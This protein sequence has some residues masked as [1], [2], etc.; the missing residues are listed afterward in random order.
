M[1]VDLASVTNS[2]G[3][4]PAGTFTGLRA[5]VGGVIGASRWSTPPS[6]TQPT[7]VAHD[8]SRVFAF[9][10][11]PWRARCATSLARSRSPE[12]HAGAAR[13]V[14]ARGRATRD[15]RGRLVVGAASTDG[16][17]LASVTNSVGAGPAGT[18]TG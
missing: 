5:G 10:R 8:T 17:D 15:G 9:S 2:V 16:V 13:A 7:T 3:A 4:G 18:F 11:A 1:G 12:R 6:A 14:A